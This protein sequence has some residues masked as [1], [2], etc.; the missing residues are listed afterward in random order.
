V[1][2]IL[3]VRISNQ[4]G[5]NAPWWIWNEYDQKIIES[6]VLPTWQEMA[7][8]PEHV[9]L[10]DTILLIDG[11]DL[12]LRSIDIPKGS[13]R[14][15]EK[16]LPFL[17]EDD[18]AQ[19][20]TA[21][22]F[23]VLHRQGNKALIAGIDSL[24]LQQLCQL[25]R[26]VGISLTRIMPDVLAL[27]EPDDVT[28]M[29]WQQQWLVR[30]AKQQKAYVIDQPWVSHIE[31]SRWQREQRNITLLTPKV[32][33][34]CSDGWN[35]QLIDTP[36]ME[37]SRGASHSTYTLLSGAF[38][39]KNGT[40]DQWRVWRSAVFAAGLLSLLYCTQL[41]ISAQQWETERN[42]L[43]AESE[44]IFR[45]V[46]TDKQ[47]IPTVSYL[48]RQLDDELARLNGGHSDNSI[49]ALLAE[50]SNQLTS[51]KGI[52][53]NRLSYDESRGV[54]RIDLQG[55]DFQQFEQAKNSLSSAFV[56]ESGPLN[57]SGDLV[58]GSLTLTRGQ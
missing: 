32:L 27:P 41:F 23:S 4:E 7:T 2:N 29:A 24:W 18:L 26:D 44:R 50:L 30:D 25:C 37:L 8:L 15:L 54:I 48:T 1:N 17:V 22:H 40:G 42:A 58:L 43:R 11:A 57:R 12:W 45:H 14:H 9:L 38:K 46:F 49:L 31:Q 10:F 6:G 39:L 56:V 35:Q 13:G 21:L 5:A 51:L 33:V 53:I 16:M 28:L 20:A 3:I 47:R 36:E 34:E 55:S 52:Q 19:D